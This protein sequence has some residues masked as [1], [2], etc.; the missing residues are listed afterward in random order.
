MIHPPDVDSSSDFREQFSGS[1]ES[2]EIE[3]SQLAVD[4]AFVKECKEELV[5]VNQELVKRLIP[6]Q[7]QGVKFMWDAC[8]ESLDQI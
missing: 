4:T 8:F 7:A 6:H 5:V 1:D 3:D 2:E